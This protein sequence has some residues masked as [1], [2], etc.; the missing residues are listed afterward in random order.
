MSS[1]TT[2]SLVVSLIVTTP[3]FALNGAFIGSGNSLHKPTAAPQISSDT[4]SIRYDSERKIPIFI[5]GQIVEPPSGSQPLKKMSASAQRR[6]KCQT[7]LLKIGPALRIANPEEELTVTEINDAK[8]HTSETS[9]Y[10]IRQKFRGVTI[11]GAEATVHLKGDR[12]EYVGRTI[13][14]P[15]LDI[16]PSLSE[17]QAI[18]RSLNDLQANNIEVQKLSLEQQEILEYNEPSAQLIIYPSPENDSRH[19]WLIRFLFVQTCSTGGNT[20][21][22]PIPGNPSQIQSYLRSGRHNGDCERSFRQS[23]GNPYLH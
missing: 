9:H 5:S 7:F 1:K 8:N 23:K 22:M 17:K 21:W 20:L 11:L 3:V 10:K 4:L 19:T 6:A 13:A 12:A 2:L 14:T 18:D 15:N 16:V